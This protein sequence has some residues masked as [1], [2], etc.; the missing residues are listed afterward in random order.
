MKKT[1]LRYLYVKNG[2]VIQ[3][4]QTIQALKGKVPDGGPDAFLADFL[5]MVGRRRVLLISAKSRNGR[6]VKN[7]IEAR[8]FPASLRTFRKLGRPAALVYM[9]STSFFKAV[10]FKPTGVICGTTGVLLWMCYLAAKVY[11]A[12]FIH[13]RHNRVE[14]TTSSFRK[15]LLSA[16]DGF[17]IRRANAVLCHGPYLKEQ[18]KGINV[19]E[20]RIFEF[21]SGLSD[22]IEEACAFS[23]LPLP[24]NSDLKIMAYI[25][26]I[27]ADKGVLD[28]LEACKLRLLQDQTL[29]LVYAGTGGAL[30][31]LRKRISKIGLNER[32]TL[33]GRVPHSQIGALLSR[34]KV[35]ATPTRSTFPEGRCMAAMEGLAYGVPVVTP[36]FGPFPYLVKHDQNGLLFEPDSVSD[37]KA[38][39]FKII[40]DDELHQ[41]L[42]ESAR[43][44][45]KPL[46]NP[47]VRFAQAVQMAFSLGN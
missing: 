40:D 38:K 45:A 32:V 33:L 22:L 16:L 15:R 10:C 26:R 9:F 17:V 1:Q 31:D 39:I 43:Q 36:D 42:S 21:D 18:M 4:V 47:P 44:S 25:G 13:S 41:K 30:A 37:L 11:G 14:V 29:H 28:L 46:I 8:V 19:K 34:A 27:E 24:Q 2:D 7:N 6:I 20:A 23:D 12:P 5:N 3:Q 35:L